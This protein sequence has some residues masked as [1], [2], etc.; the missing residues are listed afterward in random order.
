MTQRMERIDE[1]LLQE[2]SRLIHEEAEK[3]GIVSVVAVQTTRDLSRS[4]ILIHSLGDDQEQLVKDLN[5]RARRY[6][7]VLA[8]KLNLRRTPELE[9]VTEADADTG[10]RIEAILQ[11]IHES[12]Q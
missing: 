11:Q 12:G 10:N 5:H 6:R 4:R 8:D 3:L 1:L 7:L 2:L 9:F